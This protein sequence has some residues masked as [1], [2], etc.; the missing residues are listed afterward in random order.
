MEISKYEI[1]LK[2]VES[3]SLTKTAEIMGYTQPGISMM[4]KKLEEECGFVLFHRMKNGGE[5]TGE[6]KRMIPI[7]RELVNWQNQFEQTAAMIN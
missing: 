3:G 5:L 6:G 1:F 7:I 2:T 4:I